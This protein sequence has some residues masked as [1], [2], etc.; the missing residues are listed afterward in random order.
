MNN[1]KEANDNLLNPIVGV[2]MTVNENNIEVEGE[3]N[4][5]GKITDALNSAENQPEMV[6]ASLDGFKLSE[7]NDGYLLVSHAA[8]NE[9]ELGIVG[10]QEY[11]TS[12]DK[13]EL[14]KTVLKDSIARTASYNYK[15]EFTGSF[16]EPVIEKV[17]Y[18]DPVAPV[19]DLC[20]DQAQKEDWVYCPKC[21]PMPEQQPKKSWLTDIESADRPA[22]KCPQ[23]GEEI[24]D[25]AGGGMTGAKLNKCWNCGTAFDAPE[26]AEISIEENMP[27]ASMT[28]HLAQ[29]LQLED[30]KVAS[31]NE[32]IKT[33][34]VNAL[35]SML[36]SMGHGS[37]KIAEVSESSTGYDV[38]ATIDSDGAL[39]AVSIPVTVKEGKVVLPKKALVSELISKGLNIQAA[40]T[41]SFSQEVLNKIAE[42]EARIAYEA[43]EAED[44]I[45]EKPVAKQASGSN[46]EMFLSDTDVLEVQKHLLPN[47]EEMKK[48]DKISDGADQWELVDT[49]SNQNDKNEGSASIWKFKKCAPPKA[50]SK[51]PETKIKA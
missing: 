38:M 16:V 6:V 1:F 40:L 34:A 14:L 23:C 46:N 41:E 8:L 36:Q 27:R 42:T 17:A 3:E 26:E 32:K 22:V 15:L 45:A 28:D 2:N 24:W 11:N 12:K 33:E 9:A 5:E 13:A 18:P 30:Q 51:E 25:Y 10:I 48:G 21:K 29:S 4:I 31:A 49:D 19:C 20:K 35:V 44:I 37:S 50:D 43:K 47:H 7:R 39:R